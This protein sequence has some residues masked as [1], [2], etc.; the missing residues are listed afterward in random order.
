MDNGLLAGI[1]RGEISG[2]RI[3]SAIMRFCQ[4]HA[5]CLPLILAWSLQAWRARDVQGSGFTTR[6]GKLG[7]RVRHLAPCRRNGY[8]IARETA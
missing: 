7:L 3:C 1:F 6:G 5:A 8:T 2:D 4:R